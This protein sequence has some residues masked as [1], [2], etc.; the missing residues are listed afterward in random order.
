MLSCANSPTYLT[1]TFFSILI[2]MPEK[3]II[4]Y[5]CS[6]SPKGSAC[7]TF[8][9][10]PRRTLSKSLSPSSLEYLSDSGRTEHTASITEN[11][12][13]LASDQNSISSTSSNVDSHNRE[14]TVN[15]LLQSLL[16]GGDDFSTQ[17]QSSSTVEGYSN[18]RRESSAFHSK[19]DYQQNQRKL[20]YQKKKL[21][22]PATSSQ[23]DSVHSIHKCR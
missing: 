21:L 6:L 2:E 15:V 5:P 13:L 10:P 4:E 16:G 22:P 17:S 20:S 1:L 7:F 23:S 3:N 11:S 9:P 19:Q 8:R 12:S 18:Y 14:I